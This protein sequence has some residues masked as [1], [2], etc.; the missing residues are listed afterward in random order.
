MSLKRT[1]CAV[2][3]LKSLFA[4]YSKSD[5]ETLTSL[6][7]S[8]ATLSPFPESYIWALFP[9]LQILDLSSCSLTSLP[10]LDLVSVLPSLKSIDLSCNS[11]ETVKPLWPFGRLKHLEELDFRHNPIPCLE[12]RTHVLKELLFPRE[13]MRVRLVKYLTGTYLRP[14]LRPVSQSKSPKRGNLLHV[15]RHLPA[16][17]PRKGLFPV[18]QVLNG[19]VILENELETANPFAEGDLVP[20]ETPPLYARNKSITCKMKGRESVYPCV[21]RKERVKSVPRVVKIPDYVGITTLAAVTSTP[22]SVRVDR[23]DLHKL[24]RRSHYELDFRVMGTRKRSLVRIQKRKEEERRL[25]SSHPLS[26]AGEEDTVR[27]E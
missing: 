21:D 7:L 12:V 11:F 22:K 25:P 24:H 17:T 6:S 16:K 13:V 19:A 8:S 27:Q 23:G 1:P 5:L 2:P 9:N 4:T 18:L 15:N 26:V 3:V 20:S 10:S 14:N